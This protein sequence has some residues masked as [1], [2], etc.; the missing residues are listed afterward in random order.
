MS[1]DDANQ[2]RS[3]ETAVQCERAGA[4]VETAGG[5]AGAF[6]LLVAALAVR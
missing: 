1:D 6:F 2:L 5:G 4:D 3:A